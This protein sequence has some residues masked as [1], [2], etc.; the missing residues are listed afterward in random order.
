MESVALAPADLDP[1]AL[2]HLERAIELARAARERGDHPFGALLVTADGRVIEAMN[3]VGT[4]HNPIGH[5]ETNLVYDA[6]QQLA[7]AE[8]AA[9][10][11]YTSTEPCIMCT[12]AIYW[13][14]IP[15]VVFALSESGLGAL[16]AEQEGVPTLSIPCREVFARGGRPV[17]VLG[18]VD[19]PEAT[20]V[21]E[22]FWD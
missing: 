13:A 8:L 19:L 3:T 7:P 10:T 21:H 17:E 20:A 15:T 22:D 4:G 18:P 16:V 11:L 6:G 14:G 1:A 9:S 2:A 5:A 12:G